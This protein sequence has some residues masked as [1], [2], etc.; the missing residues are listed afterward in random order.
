KLALAMAEV[1]EEVY[2]VRVD[3]DLILA[4]ALLHDLG[5]ATSYEE[6]EAGYKYSDFARRLDHL[7]AVTAELYARGAP[8]ELIHAV[9]A[10]HGRGSPVPPNTPEALIVHLADN[11]DAQFAEEVIR[12]ARGIVRARLQ[13]LGEEPTDELVDAILDRL[14]PTE[15]F[16]TRVREGRDAV[17]E[18]IAEAL[19]EVR[20]E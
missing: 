11:A 16:L 15:V 10:H 4:A 14:T 13:E 1:F 2:G 5:K 6:G 20:E 7:T 3:R 18:L 17:R 8:L 12:A 19:E 9:A